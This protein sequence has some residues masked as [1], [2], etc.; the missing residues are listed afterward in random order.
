MDLQ[1]EISNQIEDLLQKN[2]H[3]LTIS[4]IVKVVQINRS[5]ARQYL[6][7]L[8]IS[9]R[10]EKRL[11]GRSK[12]YMPSRRVPLSPVL[13]ISSDFVILLDYF[14]R[15]I[16]A[17]EPFLKFVGSTS[18]KLVGKHIENTAVAQVFDESFAQLIEKLNEGIIG[19]EW[20]G[21]IEFSTKNVI[22]FCRIVPTVFDDVRY[23]EDITN[24]IGGRA[25]RRK[26]RPGLTDNSVILTRNKSGTN[27]PP[28]CEKSRRI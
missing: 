16:F 12:I 14:L 22:L 11:L 18:K 10:L 13:S 3:G 5:T 26:Q 8:L 4:E 24:E 7:N 15:I 21:E 23:S 1:K 27:K 17:N 19:N 25:L 2:P 9:G 20:S 28:P 6:E